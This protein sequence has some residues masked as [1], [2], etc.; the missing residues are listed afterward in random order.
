[1]SD[2]LFK[3]EFKKWFLNKI[4]LSQT[5]K[6]YANK[7]TTIKILK[8]KFSSF[9]TFAD[10]YSVGQ[11]ALLI[12]RNQTL[13]ES[14]LPIPNNPSYDNAVIILNQLLEKSNEILT[15]HNLQNIV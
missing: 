3:I 10:S 13:L 1:M 7:G 8:D 15:K 2:Q 12:K 9:L 6:F 14:I 4:I 5:S 11:L